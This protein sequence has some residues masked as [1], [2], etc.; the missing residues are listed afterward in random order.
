MTDDDKKKHVGAHLEATLVEQAREKAEY[1]QIKS[2]IEQSLVRFVH[3]EDQS[4]HARLKTELEN[5]TDE[6]AEKRDQIRQLESEIERNEARHQRIQNRIDELNRV[7]GEFERKL[8]QIE[9]LLYDGTRITERHHLVKEAAEMQESE[10]LTVLGQL[11]ERNP[12]VPEN[13]YRLAKKG[14][15]PS[16]GGCSEDVARGEE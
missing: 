6:N 7:E 14:E 3:G 5:I 2:V 11:K 15:S 16:W 4:E 8:S 9:G 10:P 1:G 13:A 12:G